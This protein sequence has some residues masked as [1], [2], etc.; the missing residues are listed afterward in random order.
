MRVITAKRIE[1]TKACPPCIF[2]EPLPLTA[3]LAS[4]ASLARSA[5]SAFVNSVS[6]V[7]LDVGIIA[8]VVVPFTDAPGSVVTFAVTFV[9]GIDTG[10]VAESGAGSA[11][12]FV[13]EF[14]VE[15]VAGIGSKEG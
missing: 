10:F 8:I 12:E 4:S 14:V 6:V 11:A 3:S 7:G 2:I 1:A 15:F 5:S 9:A 13:V